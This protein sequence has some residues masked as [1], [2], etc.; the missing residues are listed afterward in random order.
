MNSI[1]ILSIIGLICIFSIIYT[2]YF[3]SNKKSNYT[4]V[5]YHNVS[6]NSNYHCLIMLSD[7]YKNMR[8]NEDRWKVFKIY[9]YNNYDEAMIDYERIKYQME[10]EV[11]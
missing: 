4:T 5:C 3:I 8:F 7:I 2:G 10:N 1:E 11:C 9:E 6:D